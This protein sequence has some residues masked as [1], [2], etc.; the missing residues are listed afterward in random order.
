MFEGIV[1]DPRLGVVHTHPDRGGAGAGKIRRVHLAANV[2]VGAG[3]NATRIIA[4]GAVDGPLRLRFPNLNIPAVAEQN[5]Q[6]VG[7]EDERILAAGT[8]D[9]A[10]PIGRK[11]IARIIVNS[12]IHIELDGK[13]AAFNEIMVRGNITVRLQTQSAR[14]VRAAHL[15]EVVARRVL[16]I[17]QR[18]GVA[19]LPKVVFKIDVVALGG[20]V[21]RI[22]KNQ[23]VRDRHLSGSGVYHR[24]QSQCDQGMERGPFHRDGRRLV[25][26]LGDFK[27]FP[28]ATTLLA[29]TMTK[30]VSGRRAGP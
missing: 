4:A 17:R 3:G 28:H 9:D 24:A 20:N 1:V 14:R 8:K 23:F 19:A 27:V 2:E 30:S 21:E 13:P 10:A 12:W 11:T 29:R 18:R 26:F 22:A 7:A 6:A 25:S 16:R 15:R 5:P